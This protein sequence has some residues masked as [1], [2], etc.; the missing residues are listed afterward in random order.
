MGLGV[1]ATVLAVLVPPA[2]ANPDSADVSVQL[3]F[4]GHGKPH[5]KVGELLPFTATVTNEGPDAA[6]DVS[7]FFGLGDQLNPVAVDCATGTPTSSEACAF[8]GLSAGQT[9][10]LTFVATV[11]CFPAGESRTPSVSAN[12]SSV[13]PDP[14]STNN[15]VSLETR[16]TG[17]NGFSF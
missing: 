1:V 7:V 13:T 11:C 15:R 17:P 14:D 9:V 12:A 2:G 4:T 3:T 10:M 5:G 16:I 6:Q 8:A